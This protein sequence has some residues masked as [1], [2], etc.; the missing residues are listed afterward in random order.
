MKKLLNLLQTAAAHVNIICAGMIL[1]FLVI[2]GVFNPYA[3]FINH[4]Y[5][6]IVLS[7]WVAAALLTS[8]FSI[9]AQ[10]REFRRRQKEAA[11]RRQRE[12]EARR[13]E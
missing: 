8:I 6:K 2:E 4:S 5:T 1:T 10:R 7:V 9:A 3:G 12:R 13:G 11:R